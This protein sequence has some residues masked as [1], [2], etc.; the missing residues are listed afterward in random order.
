MKG[1]VP[2]DQ[3]IFVSLLSMSAFAQH[4]DIGPQMFRALTSLTF[5]SYLHLKVI[6]RMK[7]AM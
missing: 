2:N 3:T 1:R 5:V 6:H 4:S 7:L